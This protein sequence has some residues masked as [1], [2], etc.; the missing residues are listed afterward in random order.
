MASRSS[1]L[2][3]VLVFSLALF[4]GCGGNDADTPTNPE[5]TGPLSVSVSSITFD[6]YEDADVFTI[7]NR[8]NSSFS[9][10]ATPSDSWVQLDV[11]SGD[12]DVGASVDVSVDIARDGF[13]SGTHSATIAIQTDASA[14]ATVGV[15]VNHYDDA[16]TLD[17]AIA[18]A[19]YD[20][21]NDA[22]VVV[23][24]NPSE[25]H[26]IDAEAQTYQSVS[27][28]VTP[29]C[30]SVRSDGAFAAVGHNGYVSYV[31]LAT[32]TVDQTYPV[33][34]DALDIVLATND[35]VYVFPRQNQWEQIRCIEL[36]GGSESLQT[37]YQIY[38]G[39]LAKI[40]PSGD[41]IYGADNGLSPSDFEKYDIRAG[42]ADYMYDSPYH[43]D[44]DFDG[45]IWISDDGSRLFARSGNVFNASDD[46]QTDM[47]YAGSLDGVDVVKWAQHSNA[48]NNIYVCHLQEISYELFPTY[49]VRVYDGTF[50][51]HQ[52]TYT[53]PSMLIPNGRGGGNF[54]YTM[55]HYCSAN[56]AG[57]KLHVIGRHAD[58]DWWAL[59]TIDIAP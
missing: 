31:N 40:H 13:S 9:W 49:D 32:R 53:L 15:A 52:T 27:L 34:A 24:Q 41:Y 43:G 23:S 55:G 28:S 21:N 3:I 20:S 19:E 8:G 2:L 29:Q 54:G 45:D 58:Y 39:T 5:P 33:T 10:T 11:T 14:N 6:Y 18:D 50:L 35:W 57:T 16:V 7:R 25:L 56:A 48:T 59:A 37:G 1:A 47:T 51:Q 38:A 44:Y 36:P 30:V 22:W 4:A 42:A 26:V 17:F 12:L 46:P